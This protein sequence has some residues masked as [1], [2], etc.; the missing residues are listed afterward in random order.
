MGDDELGY[1]TLEL[2]QI[3]PTRSW[4]KYEPADYSTP[5]GHELL[6][7]AVL[8]TEDI[9]PYGYDRGGLRLSL[10]SGDTEALLYVSVQVT[11]QGYSGMLAPVL[12]NDSQGSESL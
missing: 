2:D 11:P 12:E 6:G 10:P 8:T 4:A 5:P 7:K 9:W 1:V 3:Q